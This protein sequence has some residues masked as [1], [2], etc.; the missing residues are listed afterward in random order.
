MCIWEAKQN[1]LGRLFRKQH[2]HVTA[3]NGGRT[4]SK[5]DAVV[6]WSVRENVQTFLKYWEI[7]DRHKLIQALPMTSFVWSN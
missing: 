3:P 6:L 7:H 2:N 1:I 5:P 4:N